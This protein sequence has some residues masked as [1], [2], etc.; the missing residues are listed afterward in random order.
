ME[1]AILF[2]LTLNTVLFLPSYQLCLNWKQFQI[3]KH[4]YCRN[5]LNTLLE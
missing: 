1:K 5:E 4:Q 3:K 2:N